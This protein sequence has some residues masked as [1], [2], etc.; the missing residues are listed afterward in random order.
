MLHWR[1]SRD[2]NVDFEVEFGVS[3]RS[4]NCYPRNKS[5]L[6]LYLPVCVMLFA[7][8]LRIVCGV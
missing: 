3:S 6:G 4:H 5:F 2:A 7:I 1:E 8:F